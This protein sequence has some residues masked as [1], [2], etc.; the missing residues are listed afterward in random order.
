[1][2]YSL[3]IHSP[4]KYL[5]CFQVLPTMNKASVNIRVHG[6]CVD[7]SSSPVLSLPCLFLPRLDYGMLALLLACLRTLEIL[8]LGCELPCSGQGIT[9]A[10]AEGEQNISP[11]NMLW[12]H[13][14]YFRLIIFKKQQTLEKLWKQSRSYPFVRDIYKKNLHLLGYLP[15]CTKRRKMTLNSRNSYQ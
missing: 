4:I 12:W 13:K 2:H 11:L 1:M 7:I 10:R 5:G 3:F 14:D 6:S 9:R 8:W 15:L